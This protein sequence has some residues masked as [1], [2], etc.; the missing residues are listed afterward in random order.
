ML[1]LLQLKGK[2]LLMRVLGIDYG[3]RRIGLALSDPTETIATPLDT[4][5]RRRGKRAPLSKIE[6]IAIEK[7]AEHLVIGLPLNLEGNETEWSG[8]VRAFGASLSKRMNLQ[9]SFVDERMTSVLAE[10]TVRSIGLP[11]T[12]RE[13]KARI[14][15]AAAQLILQN[16]LD[17][18]K[19]TK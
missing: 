17:L 6:S 10:R 13:N 19:H 15:A 11:K 18:R 5:I 9:V 16:W 2:H 8:E 4:L 12:K 1:I 3:M 7:G 14:D